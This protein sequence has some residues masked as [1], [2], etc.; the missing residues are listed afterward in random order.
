LSWPFRH[1]IIEK[2]SVVWTGSSADLR[3]SEDIHHRYL[4]V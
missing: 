2:G 4:G 3:D 1:Y